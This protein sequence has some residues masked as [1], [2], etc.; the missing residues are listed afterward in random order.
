M[1]T[2]LSA[3]EFL[4]DLHKVVLRALGFH[5]D[6]AHVFKVIIAKA[7]TLEWVN[8]FF[9]LLKLSGIGRCERLCS[10]AGVCIVL[11]A[12]ILHREPNYSTMNQL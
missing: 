4:S 10:K 12:K 1:L 2:E 11:A 7:S 9:R 6:G 8:N 5:Y 3:F